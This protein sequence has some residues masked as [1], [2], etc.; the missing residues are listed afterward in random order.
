MRYWCV[1]GTYLNLRMDW[2][3][4]NISSCAIFISSYQNRTKAHS[5]VSNLDVYA[6]VGRCVHLTNVSTDLD[7]GENRG[8]DVE[9]PVAYP[10][11][12]GH[13]GGAAVDARLDVAQDLLELLAV[14]LTHHPKR[15]TVVH[16]CYKLWIN[17][18]GCNFMKQV[19]APE[20]PAQHLS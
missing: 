16:Q 13:E 10:V 11:T 15:S 18:C 20:V 17:Q 5:F 12:A 19:C 2:I 1:V 7:V 9:A 6:W 4:P 14:D 8:L 3:G